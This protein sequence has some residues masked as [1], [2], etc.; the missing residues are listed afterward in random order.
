[1]TVAMGN[2]SRA[3]RAGLIASLGRVVQIVGQSNADTSG[4]STGPSPISKPAAATLYIGGVLQ[5]GFSATNHGA[6]VGFVDE[7]ITVAGRSA[8]TVLRHG[9][10]GTTLASWAATHCATVI[11][12]ANAI[13]VRP[14][15]TVLIQGEAESATSEAAALGWRDDFENFAGRLRGAYGGGH[16]IVICRIRTTDAVNYP[17]HA[18]MRTTQN[19]VGTTF[20]HVSLYHVDTDDDGVATTL[21]TDGSG[22]VH[23]TSATSILAGRRAARVLLNAGI[24]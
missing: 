1:M 3:N 23:F 2:L 22:T 19:T 9:I 21:V 20:P 5:A 24:L 7:V 17:H 18:V 11:G 13:P 4:N 8:V 10:N 6:E 14:V 12:H 16:G 15:A